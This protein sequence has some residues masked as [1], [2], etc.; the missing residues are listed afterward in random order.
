MARKQDPAT[1]LTE[2][3]QNLFA[4]SNGNFDAIAAFINERKLALVG[5]RNEIQREI[6]WLGALHMA[7]Q[8]NKIKSLEQKAAR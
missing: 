2:V 7:L 3:M 1:A 8:A 5:A 6:E 4:D